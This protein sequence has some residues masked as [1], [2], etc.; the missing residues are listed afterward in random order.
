MTTNYE[1]EDY[2]NKVK[3]K[4]PQFKGVFASN[5]L[6]KFP[7]N[8]SIII[9]YSPNYTRGTHWIGIRH[10]NSKKYAPEY[11]DSYGFPPDHDDKILGV[12]TNFKKFLDEN[13][14]SGKPIKY[15][16]IDLQGY[17][18]DVCGEYSSLF[19][20][21]GLPTDNVDCWKPITDLNTS[22]ERDAQVK[23]MVRIRPQTKGLYG[24]SLNEAKAF[25]DVVNPSVPKILNH[26]NS[27]PL[28][29]YLHAKP[30]Y[31][32]ASTK[33]R[34]VEFLKNMREQDVIMSEWSQPNFNNIVNDMPCACDYP[35][36][37]ILEG[38]INNLPDNNY[39]YLV[40][41]DKKNILKLNSLFKYYPD[42]Y[43]LLAPFN[44][45][46]NDEIAYQNDKKRILKK[47]KTI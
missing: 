43:L 45:E 1:I 28:S 30:K 8:S 44:N 31:V 21:C 12:K 15:N 24:G 9:N 4:Y 7:P 41:K 42:K 32:I 23:E 17:D 3:G 6:K 40:K 36:D 25:F 20:K 13:N 2:F 11:F 29:L 27:A 5:E 14:K 35:E 10:L 34:I 19:I 22:Q 39:N 47:I 38:Y 26:D 16:H 33:K 37:T 18:T 46:I